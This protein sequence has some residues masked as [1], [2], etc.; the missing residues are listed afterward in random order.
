VG[1]VHLDFKAGESY[2]HTVLRR[3]DGGKT[4]DFYRKD[5]PWIYKVG[6]VWYRDICS[7]GLVP[8][9]KGAKVSVMFYSI[10][11]GNQ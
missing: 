7:E 3:V 10:S 11:K 9:A 5:I 4:E 1:C 8:L 6:D 2:A